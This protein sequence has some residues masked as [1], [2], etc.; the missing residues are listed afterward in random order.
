MGE[1]LRLELQGIAADGIHKR[2]GLADQQS[3]RKELYEL[4]IK[5]KTFGLL[6]EWEDEIGVWISRLRLSMNY[7]T[8]NVVNSI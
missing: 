7:P 5:L 6:G 4:D 2:F 3:L 8:A 1:T